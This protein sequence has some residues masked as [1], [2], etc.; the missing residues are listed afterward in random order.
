MIK[1]ALFPI[2]PLFALIQSESGT[3]W[4]EMYQVFN[5]GHR[6]ELY[7]PSQAVADSLIALSEELGV[8][9]QVHNPPTHPAH[10]NRLRPLSLPVYIKAHLNH[11]PTHPPR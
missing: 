4:K 1:D 8:E 6:M 2:P 5:M 3:G 7:V 10:S 11:P 9:A